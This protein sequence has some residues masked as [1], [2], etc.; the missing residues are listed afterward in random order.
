MIQRLTLYLVSLCYDTC[1]ICYGQSQFDVSYPAVICCSPSF[2]PSSCEALYK[3]YLNIRKAVP[4]QKGSLM[5]ISALTNQQYG[6]WITVAIPCFALNKEDLQNQLLWFLSSLW[7]ST[8]KSGKSQTCLVFYKCQ[9]LLC[10]IE[11]YRYTTALITHE[12]KQ[13]VG[14][15]QVWPW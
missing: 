10:R 5:A 3:C 6:R 15:F 2:Q 11:N 7:N 1:T 14:R 12:C 4:L 13:E 9:L 8:Q